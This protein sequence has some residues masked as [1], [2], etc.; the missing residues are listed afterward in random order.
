MLPMK[1][2]ADMPESD[3]RRYKIVRTDTMVDVHPGSLILSASVDSGLCML[4]LTGGE[5]KEEN[6]GPYG[7]RIVVAKR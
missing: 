5:A 3:R 2:T 6:F 7:L 4:R 1:L